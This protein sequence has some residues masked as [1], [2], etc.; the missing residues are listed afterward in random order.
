[1]SMV[2]YKE[3]ELLHYI[4]FFM[5]IVQL[6]NYAVKI[7]FRKMVSIFFVPQFYQTVLNL[8]I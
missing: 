3:F 4:Q 1:M 8:D 6:V 5:I 7:L 2:K